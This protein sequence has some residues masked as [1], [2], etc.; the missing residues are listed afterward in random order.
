MKKNEVFRLFA[1]LCLSVLLHACADEAPPLHDDPNG[2]PDASVDPPYESYEGYTLE[3]AIEPWLSTYVINQKVSLSATL[4]DPE[5]AEVPLPDGF[6]WQATPS[7][8]VAADGDSSFRLRSEGTV[9]FEGC[10]RDTEGEL[11]VCERIEI[12]VDGDRPTL[13]ITSPHPGAEL[14]RSETPTIRVA[15][16]LED[17]NPE[18]RLS[19]FVNG[20]RAE[21]ASDGSFEVEL[22]AEFG[23]Q[24]I[25]V[26]ASDGFHTAVTQRFDVLIADAYL[27]S[28]AE[29]A[30]RFMLS[31]ALLL[32]LGQRFFDEMPYGRSL[33]LT[34]SP[35]VASDLAGILELVIQSLD[36]ASLLGDGPLLG[37]GPMSLAIEGA[38]VGESIVDLN[39]VQDSGLQLHLDLYDVFLETR[40]E[41]LLELGESPVSL[42]VE[43][44]LQTDL[45][46]VFDL[47]IGL[48]AGG[49]LIVEVT[50]ADAMVGSLVGHFTGEDGE[51]LNGLIA[52]AGEGF[53]AFVSDAIETTLVPMLSETLP[54]ILGG[55][56]GSISGIFDGMRFELDTGFGSPVALR[57][58]SRLGTLENIEHELRGRVE[59]GIEIT[60]EAD[61]TPIHTESRG[62]P[63]AV[64][65]PSAPLGSHGALQIAFRQDLING[66]L[67]S[68]WNVGLLEAELNFEGI[69]LSVSGKLPPVVRAAPENTSCVI[70]GARCDAILQI[71]QLELNALGQTFALH[72]EAGVKLEMDGGELKIGLSEAPEVIVWAP[73]RSSGLLTPDLVKTLVVSQ[74]WDS[75]AGS[76]GDSFSMPLPLPSAAD[77]G[78]GELAPELGEAALSIEMVGGL[79][80]AGGYLG[81]GADLSFIAP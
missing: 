72:V 6:G 7:T 70:E 30:A 81:L 46:T 67:Y 23:I 61:G 68:L 71:G 73:V 38:S 36:I 77:L 32:R 16:M 79:G 76:F 35:I 54:E 3:L 29:D 66:L 57:L 5:G 18:A 15:G 45:F 10:L 75:L 37:E 59:A 53:G 55:L 4:R 42:T 27:P 9:V 65:A 12:Y 41:V 58:D 26:E 25:L 34:N 21:L 50:S 62:I 2:D 19:V 17:T 51:L 48:D 63:Q 8:H 78:L 52:L 74:V 13:V 40:G 28:E 69:P 22:E 47:A 11:V 33:D 56:L 43:G 60:L 64:E 49:E 31:D 14:V 20:Q 24:H 80:I 39:I 1:L 44:G